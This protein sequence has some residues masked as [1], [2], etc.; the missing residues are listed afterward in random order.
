MP[1]NEKDVVVYL[2]RNIGK[3]C[4]PGL[5]LVKSLSIPGKGIIRN[6]DD[7]IKITSD[8]AVKKAD[9]LINDVGVSIKQKGA[10]FLYNR[11]QRATLE[12]FFYN[13]HYTNIDNKLRRIDQEISDFHNLLLN[14]RNRPWSTFFSEQEFKLLLYFLMMVGSA[15]IGQS[16]FPAKFILEAPVASIS[17]EEINF[18]TYDEYFQKY[19]FDISIAIRRSWVGQNSKSENKRSLG[20]I[21][22]KENTPW[23]FSTIAG[24]PRT[25]WMEFTPVS[26]R[27]TVYYLMIEKTTEHK[28]KL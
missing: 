14:S 20:L 11:L 10:S 6:V 24:T 13:L 17:Q 19:K 15:N 8:N 18:L 28:V 9:I 4:L 25:G 5:G 3:I 21:K 26:Q 2:F 23:V 12:T 22:K 16:R 7:C 1:G 27:R